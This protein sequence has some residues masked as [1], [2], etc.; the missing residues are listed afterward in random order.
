MKKEK[1]FEEALRE[2]EEIVNRLE[3]GDLPLE[4]ALTLFEEGV[5]LSRSCHAKLDEAQ[6]RV[7]IVLKDESG[8][9]TPHPF[10]QAEDGEDG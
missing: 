2:L 10:E 4:E 5:R 1:V 3:Q 9:M 6:K 7:E 8:K